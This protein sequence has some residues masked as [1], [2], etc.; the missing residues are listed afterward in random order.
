MKMHKSAFGSF[1]GLRATVW[2]W[3]AR[4]QYDVL[5]AL[6]G[7]DIDS[8]VAQALKTVYTVTLRQIALKG[9]NQEPLVTPFSLRGLASALEADPN[10]SVLGHYRAHTAL[11][12]RHTLRHAAWRGYGKALLLVLY[13]LTDNTVLAPIMAL[14]KTADELEAEAREAIKP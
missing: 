3:S 14:R 4:K 13:A 1:N 12:L 10:V 5:T 2:R 8:A 9:T 11:A 7:P 6:R